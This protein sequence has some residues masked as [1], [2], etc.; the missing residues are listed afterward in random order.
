MTNKSQL[1]QP[2]L[3]FTIPFQVGLEGNEL[4]DKWACHVSL[5]GVVFERPLP[6]VD[7]QALIRSVLLKEWQGKLDAAVYV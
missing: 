4:V 1:F 5:N 6:L 3:H 2:Q 7:F